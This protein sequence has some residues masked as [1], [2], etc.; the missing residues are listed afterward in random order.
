MAQE[1]KQDEVI[2][3]NLSYRALRLMIGVLGL[4]LPIILPLANKGVMM[5]SI[6]KF[7]Y[8][9][10]SIFFTSILFAIGLFLFSYRGKEKVKGEVSDNIITNF[11]GLFAMMTALIPTNYYEG[12]SSQNLE[13]LKSFCTEHCF[14]IQYIHDNGSIGWVH[15]ISAIL[16]LI[17]VGYMSFFR[18]TKDTQS[19]PRNLFYEVCGIGVW[20][21]LI[22]TGLDMALKWNFTEFDVFIGESIA[23]CFFGVAWLTKSGLFDKDDN[24][25][26]KF[27]LISTPRANN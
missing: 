20:V 27:K 7:Y 2:D 5:K 18:F 23:L 25:N 11:G 19:D 22:I 14:S 8:T 16:F 1:L 26:W 12:G 13:Y 15:T 3:S 24:G 4:L 6:S 21:T 9:D 17:I 10:S